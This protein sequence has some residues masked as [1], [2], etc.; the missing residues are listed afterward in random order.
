MYK[1]QFLFISYAVVNHVCALRAFNKHEFDL[2]SKSI[3]F[4]LD[5]QSIVGDSLST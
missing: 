2:Q 5:Y 3:V 4:A 1:V